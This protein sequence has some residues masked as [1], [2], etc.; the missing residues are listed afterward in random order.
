MTLD[1]T[2]AQNIFKYVVVFLG[3]WGVFK[4]ITPK[5]RKSLLLGKLE[6][7]EAE[8]EERDY[9]VP[10]PEMMNEAD[11]G[12]NPDQ[13]SKAMMALGTYIYSYN[14]GV[15]TEELENGVNKELANDYGLKVYR[16]RSDGKLV[17]KDLNGRDVIEYDVIAAKQTAM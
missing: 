6:V 16:R 11:L 15:S 17:V 13:A 14:N 1:R 2:Q 4:L 8:A 7:K 10:P 5:P 12:G 9:I 3:A